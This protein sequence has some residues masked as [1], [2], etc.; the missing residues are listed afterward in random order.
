MTGLADLLVGGAGMRRGRRS[1]ESLA[2]GDTVDFWRVEAFEPNRLLRLVSEMRLPGR[3]W[4]QFEVEG[5]ESGWS[6]ARPP[7][8]TLWGFPVSP[9][10]TVSTRYTRPFSRAC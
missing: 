7:Y 1:Q 8:S 5:E 4:L 2:P 6:F 3:A 9:T 10:G